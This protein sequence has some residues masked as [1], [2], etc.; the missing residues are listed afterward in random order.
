MIMVSQYC[1][2]YG[3]LRK[4]EDAVPINL[5]A[6]IVSM[7]TGECGAGANGNVA[8]NKIVGEQRKAIF[9]SLE[10]K[11]SCQLLQKN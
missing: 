9:R 1:I 6:V 11:D 10:W 3:V 7:W 2:H 5:L 8:V 4:L